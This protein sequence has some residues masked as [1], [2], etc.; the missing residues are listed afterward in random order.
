MRNRLLAAALLIAVCA[1]SSC[2]RHSAESQTVN[3]DGVWEGPMTVSEDGETSVKILSIDGDAATLYDMTYSL[4]NG[5][6]TKGKQES[7]VY[8][9]KGKGKTPPRVSF[10]FGEKSQTFTYQD[11]AITEAVD[12]PEVGDSY[13]LTENNLSYYKQMASFKSLLPHDNEFSGPRTMSLSLTA[14][15]ELV[16]ESFDWVEF[17]EWAGKTAATT[18]WGKGVGVLLDELFPATGKTTTLD[19]LLA[20]MNDISD[21]LTQMT[22]LYK[23]TTYEA[24]LN[25]R[26]KYVS[27]L[28]NCNSEYF[29][30]L[31]NVK[32]DNE[33]EAEAKVKEIV[34]AWAKNT[35]G[36]N[37]VAVQGL[38]Y[39]DFLLNTVIEQKD[40]F[41]MYDLYTYNTHAWERQGYSVREALRAGDIA[42]VAQTL[43]LTQLYHKVRDDIDDVSRAKIL[44]E[45]IVR[46]NKFSDY[47]KNRPVDRHDDMVICQ[48]EGTHFVMKRT[49][50]DYPFYKNP[51]WCNIPCLWTRGS[52]VEYFMWGPNQVEYYN[53]AFTADEITRILEYYGGRKNISDI[54]LYEADCYGYLWNPFGGDQREGIIAIQSGYYSADWRCIGIDKTISYN[55]TSKDDIV[56]RYVGVAV[57]DGSGWGGKDLKFYEWKEFY[58]NQRWVRTWIVE[59]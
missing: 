51:T 54:L 48:I 57:I 20:K 29:T 40:I 11:G 22:V 39:I 12:E 1:F 27:E 30:R 55:G 8:T 5:Y 45:N 21:Q 41:N 9:V 43:Y 26:S 46:F 32:T 47:I 14:S 28:M 53:K 6:V 2:H 58:D 36:G 56:P 59:R 34:L 17:L 33:E 3:F 23:N 31:S 35:V 24:K 16:D 44:S 38:N 25:E 7:S 50:F 19:D 52:K 13:I 15:S 37:P 42:T 4:N 10:T 18:A 49:W